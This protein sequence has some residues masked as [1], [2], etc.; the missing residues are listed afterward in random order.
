MNLL[1]IPP[2]LL[3][4]LLATT[5]NA[6]L[7]TGTAARYDPPY[8]PTKCLGSDPSQ[9]P[10]GNLFV[11]VNEGLWDNGAACGRRY[12]IRCISGSRKGC[13]ADSVD[14]TVVDHCRNCRTSFELSQAVYKL[15][16][17]RPNAIIGVEYQEINS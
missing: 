13:N 3:L 15:L 1:L 5:T 11:A 2:T 12:Q 14:V 17:R 8:I 10:P 16:T 4:L 9:F 6:E 7:G